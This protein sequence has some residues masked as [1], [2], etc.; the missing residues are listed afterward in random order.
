LR[1]QGTRALWGRCYEFEHALPYQPIAEALRSVL[2]TLQ[3]AEF[4]AWA[5]REVA[6]LVPEVL[7]RDAVNLTHPAHRH[8]TA[9]NSTPDLPVTPGLD[10]DQAHLFAG[11]TRALAELSTQGALLLVLEDLHWASVSTLH[12]LHYLARCLSGNPVLII[13]TFRPEDIGQEQLLLEL[14]RLLARDGVAR[15]LDLPRLSPAS[16]TT[17]IEEMSGAGEAVRPLADRLY[18]E[19]EGNPF[20]LMESIKALFE[21]NVIQLKEGVWQGDFSLASTAKPPL[22]PSLSDAVQARVRRLGANAQAA[23]DLAAVLGR[24]FNF[25]PFTQAWGKDEEATLEALD[26]L[27]RHRLVE[28]K[29]GRQESDFAFTHHKIQ[30]VVYQSLPRHR[31]CHLHARVGTTLEASAATEPETRAGELAYHF[32]QACLQDRSLSD[33]AIDYLIQAGQQAVQQSANQ[34]AIS[35]YQRG[36]EV[37]HSMPETEQRMKQEVKLQIA[38]AVPVTSIRGY[39]S[40]ETKRI[41]DRASE[42]CQTLGDM[43]DLFT[44]LTGLT[45]YYGVSGD[46]ETGYKLAEQML[47]TAQTAGENDWLVEAYSQLGGV[48]F[49]CG[50]LHEAC[51]FWDRGLALYDPSRHERAANRFGHDPVVTCLGYSGLALWLLW[52]PDQAQAQGQ[53]L[54]DLLPL[55]SHPASQAYSYCHL[56]KQACFRREVDAARDHAEAAI[57][58]TRLHG[59]SSWEA[60]ASALIGWALCEQ[61]QAAQGWALLAEGVQAW[62]SRSLAHW[63]PFLLS[64]QAEAAL[65]MQRLRDGT[66]AI[67]SALEIVQSYGDR[68]WLAELHRLQGDLLRAGGADVRDVEAHFQQAIEI[69]H[70]QDVRMLELRAATSLARLWR[71]QGRPQA[72]RR[73]LAQIYDTFS[74]GFDTRDLQEAGD[75]LRELA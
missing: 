47:A 35:Y 2:P 17:L 75:L 40:P 44:S 45:R 46:F 3:E 59:L 34:D 4:P 28:E 22:T 51:E 52:Y 71:D 26:E 7:E 19:T 5:L 9:G 16:V 43:P 42:L 58:I 72:A 48:K 53:K 67:I 57:Q 25:E 15:Q 39:A 11:I 23:L 61:G 32:E 68:Y 10:P 56:A 36:L 18:K 1:W 14:H 13:G 66:D 64:L 12:L 27:L 65:K 8:K 20:F 41:F 73:P 6:R 38:L 24:E 33:K 62:R 49:A 31:R 55:M 21:T 29:F 74:E 54:S 69:A 70:Q 63:S 37:L 50:N 60:L 30:E